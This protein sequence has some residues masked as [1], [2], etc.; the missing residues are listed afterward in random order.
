MKTKLIMGILASATL[1]VIPTISSAGGP[2]CMKVHQMELIADERP[3]VQIALLL[4]TSNSMDGL[5]N[6][7]KSQLWKIVNEFNRARRDG[8]AP[9]LQVA[10]FEYGNN[11][12]PATEGFIRMVLPFTDDLDRVSEKLFH[13][14]TN[15]GEEY[16]G[17]AINIA[18]KELDW[19]ERPGAFRAIFIA[20]NEPFSQGLVDYHD[21]C[22]KAVGRGI[23]VNTIHCGPADIGMRTGWTE[24]ARMAEGKAMN[25]DQDHCRVAIRTPCDDELIRLSTALNATYIPY[26]AE[27][28]VGCARQSEQDAL[29][30]A[31]GQVEAGSNVERA[32]TKAGGQYQNAGWDLVDAITNGK[33]KLEDV[34][35]KDLPEAMQK[36]SKDERSEYVNKQLA[37]RKQIQEK[38][39]QLNQERTKFIAEQEKAASGQPDTL[40]SAIL[41]VV[42]E[43]LQEQ[44]FEMSEN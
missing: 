16:C 39:N 22:R 4:D 9:R 20:G 2:D 14:S 41:R 25:I 29:A 27:G 7:A 30:S 43:Q 21:S 5:I 8:K 3:V 10:L 37:S 26:G 1:A 23:V 28:A 6:Q 33:C 34:S 13:L 17:H 38:I 31:P 32:V 36:M 19:N 12:L 24:G 44:K 35:E 42:R 18:L 40:D 15:G 11:N